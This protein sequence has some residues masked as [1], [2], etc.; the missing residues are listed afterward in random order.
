M[1]LGGKPNLSR[2]YFGYNFG[3]RA[4]LTLRACSLFLSDGEV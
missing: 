1:Y 3:F 2:S 4:E